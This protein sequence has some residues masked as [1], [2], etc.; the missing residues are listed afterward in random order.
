MGGIFQEI[1]I[2]M[3]TRQ[4]AKQ[5]INPRFLTSPT[6]HG[7]ANKNTGIDKLAGLV[8]SPLESYSFFYPKSRS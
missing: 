8:A 1:K 6:N 5:K 2:S 4:A 3:R 7:C